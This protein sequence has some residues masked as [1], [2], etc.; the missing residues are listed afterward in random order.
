VNFKEEFLMS[1]KKQKPSIFKNTQ[2][3][4]MIALFTALSIV[5]GKQLSITAGAFRISFEN[6]P[7]LM[8]GIFI[9]PVAGAFVGLCADIVGC[10]MFG[11][12]INP[13][14]TLGGVSIG[15][16]SGIVYHSHIIKAPKLRLIV[17]IAAA[18]II[19]SMLI[20]SVGLYVYYHYAVAL[21]LLR[22]P[23]YIVIGS[24]EAFII[25]SLSEN[26]A[27]QQQLQKMRVTTSYRRY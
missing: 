17:A 26:T 24:A 9:G 5:F 3:M 18:H 13:I 10:I 6:L 25:Y 23:L 14:I 15:F 4:V 21:L 8:A 19:G 12:N 20:K 11:I 27:F 1:E 16:I 22:V 2:T 7:I